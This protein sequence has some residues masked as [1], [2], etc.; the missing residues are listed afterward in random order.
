ME[1]ST[2]QYRGPPHRIHRSPAYYRRQERRKAA[3]T[4]DAAVAASVEVTDLEPSA[5]KVNGDD[6]LNM[7]LA[8]TAEIGNS[9]DKNEISAVEAETFPCEICDFESNWTNGLKIHMSRRHSRIEQIGGNFDSEGDEN[10]WKDGN[11]SQL[12]QSFLDVN[13]IIEESEKKR[14]LKKS[15]YWEQ[16][17]RHLE[18][19][20]LDITLHGVRDEMI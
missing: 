20:C 16:E 19:A 10:Y 5:G 15:K 11:I 13:K 4:A 2:Q 8:E 7:I 14:K 1:L 6:F 17:E 12:Y 18:R 9:S 3:K